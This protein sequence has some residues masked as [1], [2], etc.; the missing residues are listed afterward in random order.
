M[1]R[2]DFFE[3]IQKLRD[4][5]FT[6]KY[7]I[8]PNFCLKS[9]NFSERRNRLL[10]WALRVPPIWAILGLFEL[11]IRRPARVNVF[12]RDLGKRAL[13]TNN[14]YRKTPKPPIQVITGILSLTDGA[15]L[16]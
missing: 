16:G 7:V 6:R 5:F 1:L 10:F 4:I 9:H 3:K 13:T 14:Q 12:A 11:C 2:F 15:N 8:I